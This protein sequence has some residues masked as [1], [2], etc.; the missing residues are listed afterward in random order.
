MLENGALTGKTVIDLSRMLPGPYCS[1]LLADHGARVIAVEDRRFSEDPF[2]V[3]ALYRN[4]EHMTLNLKAQAG[5]EVFHR[6][7]CNADVLIEGFRPGVTRR[8]GVDYACMQEINP[9]LVYCSITGYGQSGPNT[10]RA[11][12]DVN[13]IAAA[14]VLD[15]IG[16]P[17]GPPVIP[18]IQLADLAGG[19]NAALGILLAL[20][21]REWTGE[22]QYVDISMS[23]AALGLLPFV[24]NQ[25]NQ[26][27]H[28]ARRG[29]FLLAHRYACYNTYET[30]DGRAI[31][32]GALEPKFWAALCTHLGLE[33]YI[34]HQL[35]DT[36][37]EEIVAALTRVFAQKTL[38]QW[39]AELY[40]LDACCEGVRT[41]DEALNHDQFQER[42][43]SLDFPDCN[44][45]LVPTLGVPVHLQHTPGSLRT[46]P[47]GFGEH[48]E[49]ILQELEYS[50]ADIRELAENGVI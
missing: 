40:A 33:E 21:A 47:A 10:D 43:M 9:G 36:R 18:G 39:E 3:S 12:H 27:G 25:N 17:L 24:L 48:T 45:R 26:T 2:F 4:K 41:L 31:S 44:G 22:G 13:Y 46:R 23:D 38:A 1:M 42:G 15:L 50:P 6:L 35:D 8:L 16:P 20:L 5:Q 19:M 32:I 7:V 28:K 29:D 49:V 34:Q 11:G 14:G 30:A 37:R